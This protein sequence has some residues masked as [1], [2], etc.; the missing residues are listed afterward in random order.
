MFREIKII[1]SATQD[2]C[3]PIKR[4]LFQTFPY[5]L[6]MGSKTTSRHLIVK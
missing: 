5:P 2:D 4:Q 3:E 6:L 1:N